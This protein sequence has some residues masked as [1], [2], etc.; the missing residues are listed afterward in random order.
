MDQDDDKDWD[1]I[2]HMYVRKLKQ[3]IH[4]IKAK[5]FKMPDNLNKDDTIKYFEKREKYLTDLLIQIC[6]K[7]RIAY[8]KNS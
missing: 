7:W 4:E 3:N 5:K 6:C 2:Y 8:V 1:D